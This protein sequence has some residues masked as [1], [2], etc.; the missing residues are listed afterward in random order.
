MRCCARRSAALSRTSAITNDAPQLARHGGWRRTSI[1]DG[2]SEQAC[3]IIATSKLRTTWNC[4]GAARDA[5]VM[6][7]STLSIL[8]RTS[9]A[10]SSK[11]MF[12]RSKLDAANCVLVRQ[13][14]RR[15][16][17]WMARKW[18]FSARRENAYA[19]SVHRIVGRQ[20]KRCLSEI[21]LVGD[22]LHLSVRK[23]ARIGNHRHRVA[24]E[25][26][27]SEDIDRLK[28]HFHKRNFLRLAADHRIEPVRAAYAPITDTYAQS[29]ALMVG[30]FTAITIPS[31]AAWA[32]FG[33]AL[34]RLLADPRAVRPTSRWPRSSPPR[35]RRCCSNSVSGVSF[36]VSE[37]RISSAAP[38]GPPRLRASAL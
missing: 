18:H 34:K 10:I 33:A 14:K 20:Y 12:R 32:L 38:S 1:S 28:W 22:G 29:V 31:A 7:P 5:P 35:S 27:I 6:R 23:T 15:A 26:P 25:L 13:D 21:E 4:W 3:A 8:M 30:L 24:A 11:I 19:S 16:N 2:S 9:P 17:V 37:V 36:G